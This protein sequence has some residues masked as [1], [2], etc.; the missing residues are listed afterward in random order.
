MVQNN[1]N[2][3]RIWVVKHTSAC[4]LGSG[5]MAGTQKRPCWFVGFT[6]THFASIRLQP[7]DL[8]Q[9]L[10][11]LLSYC[12]TSL[13]LVPMGAMF[14]ALFANSQTPLLPTHTRTH[15]CNFD[16]YVSQNVEVPSET[17][18]ARTTTVQ[19]MVTQTWSVLLYTKSSHGRYKPP[20][21][22]ELSSPWCLHHV[23]RG[24][25]Q[26]RWPF[27]A[28]IVHTYTSLERN[29]DPLVWLD[30]SGKTLFLLP[31]LMHLQ[32]L[33]DQVK[34]HLQPRIWWPGPLQPPHVH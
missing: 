11:T 1:F 24:S 14:W 18:S 27:D 17:D 29:T 5:Y 22:F 4:C 15:L 34:W 9:K 8:L 30:L 12:C 31:T 25:K 21:P 6:P 13:T 16:G 10:G 32:G 23:F 7:H 2:H 33:L 28:I 3:L 26:S 19:K 20:N